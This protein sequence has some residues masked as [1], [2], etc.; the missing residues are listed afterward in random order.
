MNNAPKISTKAISIGVLV[1]IGGSF[2][3]A[4]IMY[5]LLAVQGI[6]VTE[7][8]HELNSLLSVT[9]IIGFALTFL[10]GFVSARIAKSAE[11]I[12]AGIVGAIGVLFGLLFWGSNALWLNMISLLLTI[13]VAMLGGYA[14]KSRG[15]QITLQ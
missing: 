3:F 11:I 9:V 15:K 6:P 14:A 5:G 10:G 12:H 1:D 13:P 7:I 8:E 2:V 4:I